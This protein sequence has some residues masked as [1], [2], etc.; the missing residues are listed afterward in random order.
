MMDEGQERVQASFRDNYGRLAAIVLAQQ[1][2]QVIISIRDDGKGVGAQ[3]T[4]F[5]PESIGV[6]IGGM[7]QRVKELGGLLRVANV[8]PGTLV[9]V[10]VPLSVFT[11][12]VRA[13][14]E[15]TKRPGERRSKS[16]VAS[17]PAPNL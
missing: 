16:L 5:R 4:Q 2:E 14:V 10:A 9:E 8:H 7:R 15:P 3:I 17:H 1:H 11:K 13:A 6:G 12:E